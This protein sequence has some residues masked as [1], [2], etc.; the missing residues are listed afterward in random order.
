MVKKVVIFGAG[1]GGEKMYNFIRQF[2][3]YDIY[4]FLDNNPKVDVFLGLNIIRANEFLKTTDKN[5]YYYCIGSI[6]KD[7]IYDQ[8][9]KANIDPSHIYS[10]INFIIENKKIFM[11]KILNSEYKIGSIVYNNKSNVIFD[12]LNGFVL[13]GVEKW[14]YN[15]TSK[16]SSKREVFLLGNQ[17]EGN[18]PEEF[19]KKVCRVDVTDSMDYGIES[20]RKIMDFIILKLPC[21]V[22]CA[23]VNNLL[24]A[25]IALKQKVGDK[26]KIVSVIHG[27]LHYILRDNI[28][29]YDYVDYCLCVS[30]D[31]K[32]YLEEKITGASN[33]ILFKETPVIIPC[34]NERKYTLN[35]QQPLKIAYAARLDK[36][37]KRADLLIPFIN[38]LEDEHINY[39]LDIAGNGVLFEI[40]LEF[41]NSNNLQEKVRML[42][43]LD[44]NEME[45]FWLNHDV[46]VNFSESEGCS[47]AMLESMAAA[48]VPIFTDVFSTRHFIIDEWNGFVISFGDLDKMI[49]YVKELDYDRK[50][51]QVMGQRAYKTIKEKCDLD[52]YIDY[53]DSNIE[54]Y[55]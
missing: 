25:C 6:Y 42:G 41:V 18:P 14:S 37:H 12:L 39:Q 9:V 16:Y 10:K 5:Q 51:L 24:I 19:E 54:F 28:A 55:S 36:I 48:T 3:G 8:L 32:K 45:Q 38:A 50:K 1:S 31:S 23:H 33:K 44:F 29:V 15:L 11:D 52:K 22:Y 43:K 30:V 27:G 13:G 2:S 53:L 26:L 17:S 46:A 35:K 47:L 20:I 34:L 49:G 7:E 21:T 40:V 4:C